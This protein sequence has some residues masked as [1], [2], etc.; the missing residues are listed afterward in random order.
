[1]ILSCV[2]ILILALGG[3]LYFLRSRASAKLTN[4]DTVVL[5]DFTNTTGDSVFD[6]TLRQGLS[7]QLEQSPFLNLLS[8]GRIGQTLKLMT[9]SKDSH[10]TQEVA[11]EVCQRTASAATIEGS[12]STLG[13]QYVLALQAVNCRTGD[14]LAQE[15][16]TA[17]SKEQVLKALSEG[18]SHIREK[19][20]E[21]LSSLQKYDAPVD[22]VTTPSLEALQAYGLGYQE[23]IVKNDALASIPFFERAISLDPNFAMAYARLGTSYFN[24]NETARAAETMRKAYDLRE[25]VSEREKLYITSHYEDLVTRNIEAARKIYELWLHTYPRDD[26]PQNNLGVL[27]GEL[28]DLDKAVASSQEALRLDPGSGQ[29]YAN[30]AGAY[31][32]ANH[33]DEARSTAREAQARNL[34]SPNLHLVLY[35]LAFLEHNLAAAKHEADAVMG[36]PGEEDLILNFESSAAAHAG[37]LVKAR[38]WK[39]RAAESA[40][41]SA[42][43]ETAAAYIATGALREALVGNMS[44]A[45]EQAQ[46][47]LALSNA[48]YVEAFSAMALAVAADDAQATRLAADMAQRFPQDTAVQSIYV[49]LIRAS[50]ALAG[51]KHDKGAQ[52]ASPRS[53]QQAIDALAPTLPYELG[54]DADLLPCYLRGQAYVALGRGSDAIAEFQKIIEHPASAHFRL[55][56]AALVLVQL[57]RAHVVSG[58]VNKAKTSYQDFLALWKDADPDVPLLKQAKSEYASLH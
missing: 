39:R 30:L 17:N 16:V 15:Q 47:A 46:T 4:A 36:K 31:L 57:G 33:F 5:A 51:G 22:N 2:G 13:S 19:L 7:S 8:D 11:R 58:D 6:G 43:K 44:L 42:G 23:M 14:L 12:I 48:T 24:M 54:F 10:L 45:K 9:R 40:Q 35:R 53:A 56:L 38:E 27:Y 20:G 28:G 25:R 32:Q 18:A 49:P 52:E 41:R 50:S 34:D 29:S 26:S 1:M 3:I 21:S 55:P 37:Q